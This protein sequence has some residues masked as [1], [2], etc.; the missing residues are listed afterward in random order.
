M[1]LVSAINSSGAYCNLKG[2]PIQGVRSDSRGQ[3]RCFT[4]AGAVTTS[5][6]STQFIIQD[7]TGC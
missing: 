7:K 2:F 4:P 3:I 1:S 5:M 6:H